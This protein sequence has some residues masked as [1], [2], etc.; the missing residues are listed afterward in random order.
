MTRAT[1]L[2]AVFSLMI[3]ILGNLQAWDSDVHSA[4]LWI[5]LLVSIAIA[6]PAVALLI[7]LKQVY[8][9]SAFAVSL[10]LLVAARITS[11]I[12]LA[13]LFIIFVPAVMGLIFTGLIGEKNSV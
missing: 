8:F 5:V 11:P 6:L 3:I 4:G 2:G 13:G 7:P 1:T 12:P 9:L 10:I